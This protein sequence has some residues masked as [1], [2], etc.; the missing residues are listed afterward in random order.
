[1]TAREEKEMKSADWVII[2]IAIVWAAVII[3]AEMVLAGTPY[4]SRV[5]Q[6]LGGGAAATII[7]LGGS[8]RKLH[9]RNS[10]R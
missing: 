7:I 4:S 5:T 2:A 6:L 9:D 1:M 10:S 8:R 3:A